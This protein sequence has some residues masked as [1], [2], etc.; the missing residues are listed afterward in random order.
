MRR[1]AVVV[2]A[3]VAFVSAVLAGAPALAQTPPPAEEAPEKPRELVD[4]LKDAR[5][6][7]LDVPVAQNRNRLSVVDKFLRKE[8][9][10]AEDLR[11]RLRGEDLAIARAKETLAAAGDDADAWQEAL[12]T[13]ES[14]VR[15]RRGTQ[16]ELAAAES[17]VER[18]RNQRRA[19]SRNVHDY[20]RIRDLVVEGEDPPEVALDSSVL[21]DVPVLPGAAPARPEAD[22]IETEV[23][24]AVRDVAVQTGNPNWRERWIERLRAQSPA[25]YAVWL[26]RNDPESFSALRRI[27][28]DDFERA[29][30]K[31]D[32]DRHAILYGAAAGGP[33]GP[34]VD[35]K[36]FLR[37]E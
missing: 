21:G 19:V 32:P 26:A 25:T 5:G 23:A 28:E 2:T 1:V 10:N 17:K 36:S 4:V 8:E 35:E 31:V 16:D 15:S 13:L 7:L 29:L 14:L 12:A 33:G 11:S 37:P 22:R 27:H 3:A 34:A 30:A 6:K 18:L 9:A 24:L 20:E